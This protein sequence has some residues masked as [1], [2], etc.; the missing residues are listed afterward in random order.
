MNLGE[1]VVFVFVCV[2]FFAVAWRLWDLFFFSVWCVYFWLC[3]AFV[4]AQ[5][6]LQLPWS[7]AALEVRCAGFPSVLASL[8]GRRV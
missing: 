2:I 8:V 3:W 6:F 7:R 1:E 5:A 4:A